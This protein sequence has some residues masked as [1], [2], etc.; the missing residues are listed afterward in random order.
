MEMVK[1]KS[2]LMLENIKKLLPEPASI[3]AEHREG[4]M[5]PNRSVIRRLFILSTHILQDILY[6]VGILSRF[7]ERL[8]NA[9]CVAVKRLLCYFQ[10]V[11]KIR[12]TIGSVTSGPRCKMK[13]YKAVIIY[14]QWLG[15]R[16][17]D[18]KV[19]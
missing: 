10:G 9:H 12:I 2:T 3:E 11:Q 13:F 18:Q 4:K 14:Q 17:C 15:R 1:T 16:Y 5:V 6:S 8:T 19:H 7:I